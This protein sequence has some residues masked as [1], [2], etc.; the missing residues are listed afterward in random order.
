MPQQLAGLSSALTAR[1]YEQILRCRDAA[2]CRRALVDIAGHGLETE[3]FLASHLIRIFA[4]SGCLLESSQ[5]FRRLPFPSAFSWSAI[6]SAHP[7]PADAFRLY[8]T[9]C[10]AREGVVVPNEYVFVN[11]LRA[12]SDRSRHVRLLHGHAIEARLGSKLIVA[13]TLIDAYAKSGA[14][15]DARNVFDRARGRDVVAWNAMIAGHAR[16]GSLG[17]AVLL[18]EE[19]RASDVVAPNHV[20]W[21]ALIGGCCTRHSF[22]YFEKMRSEGISPN[23]GTF[24]TILQACSRAMD[25]AALLL[26]MSIHI[27]MLESSSSSSSSGLRSDPILASALID[28]YAKCGD[29]EG[30]RR[31]FDSSP[32]KQH[33]LVTWNTMISGYVSYGLGHLVFPLI[34]RMQEE[35]GMKP[36]H[37]TLVS[38]VQACTQ[39]GS[40]EQGRRLLSLIIEDGFY[41]DLYVGSSLVDMYCKWQQVDD[42]WRALEMMPKHNSVAWN[43]MIAAYAQQSDYT[44]ALGL[45]EGSKGIKLDEVTFISLL[46]A[47]SHCGL[48]D[49]AF[50]HIKRMEACHGISPSIHHYDCLLDG[51]GRIGSLDGAIQLEKTMALS[52]PRASASRSLLSHCRTHGNVELGKRFFAQASALDI[53]D[54]GAYVLMSELCSDVGMGD[55]AIRLEEQRKSSGA[56]K[57]PGLAFIEVDHHSYH[58]LVGGQ[59]CNATPVLISKLKRLKASMTQKGYITYM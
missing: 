34:H 19:M 4:S 10:C 33:D 11:A 40:L 53:R 20:T 5:I 45:L 24:V 15:D 2:A 51:M 30:A 1:F 25:A 17:E 44:S 47:C 38:A 48:M 22:Q 57:K 13:N 52:S 37:Y 12:C 29:F 31:V 28:M 27:Q 43:S 7:H 3:P 6:I 59:N 32:S 50:H 46:S 14:L 9:M 56:V 26:G 41:T 55:D 8:S 23:Q 21:N 54:S 49:E 16:D 18:F 35:T 36:D 58:F 39:M 42:G